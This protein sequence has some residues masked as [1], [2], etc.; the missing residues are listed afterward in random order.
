ME[1]K[2]H[3]NLIENGISTSSH[4]T[5][6]HIISLISPTTFH[7]TQLQ[8]VKFYYFSIIS[9]NFNFFFHLLYCS[10]IQPSANR[11]ILPIALSLLQLFT[12]ASSTPSATPKLS[13]PS[14]ST[15]EAATAFPSPAYRLMKLP[16]DVKEFNGSN[17][18]ADLRRFNLMAT[19]CG[20]TAT[21]KL[22][23]FSAYCTIPIISQVEYLAG[24]EDADWD[25]CKGSLKEDY[26]DSDSPQKEY[27]IPYLR[28]QAEHQRCKGAK[29]LKA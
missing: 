3:Q 12:M 28:S 19:D 18:T 7:I 9:L 10:R 2:R 11:P 13:G 5:Y 21:A 26:F 15:S 6:S 22:H 16:W 20:L 25:T 29:D 24:Y 17:A 27:Q 23:R 8:F 1:I 14:V 4:I